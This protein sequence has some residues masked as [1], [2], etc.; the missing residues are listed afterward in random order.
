MRV[1]PLS[2][3]AAP[4]PVLAPISEAVRLRNAVEE[5]HCPPWGLIERFG[6]WSSEVEAFYASNAQK[7]AATIAAFASF[8][9]GLTPS[10]KE[11]CSS[12]LYELQWGRR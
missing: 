7:E 1:A 4:R 6:L 5:A 8:W 3:A 9:E 11:A 12:A 10:Q 2:P